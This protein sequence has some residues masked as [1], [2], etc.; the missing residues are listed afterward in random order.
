MAGSSFQPPIHLD[1]N[2]E[3]GQQMAFINQNFQAV[4]NSLNPLIISDG[5]NS[6]IIL[7]KCPDGTYGLVI[8]KP[9]YDVMSLFS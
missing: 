3:P 4:A 6:R 7:G 2:Q 8:S 1:P 5:S 9:G